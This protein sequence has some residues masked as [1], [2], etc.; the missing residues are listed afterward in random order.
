MLGALGDDGAAQPEAGGVAE[1]LD[2]G[3]LAQFFDDSGEHSVLLRWRLAGRAVAVMRR[4]GPMRTASVDVEAQRLGDGGDAGVGEGRGARA[5]QGRGEV[6]DDL[7]D[8]SGGD[9]GAGQGGAAFQQY[10]ARRRGRTG[11]PS[12]AGDADAAVVPRAAGARS[13]PGEVP[14]VGVLG[15]G[16]Q[17]GR[18]VVED[19]GGRAGRG[20]LG[21]ED[22]PQRLGRRRRSPRTARCGSSARSGAGAD[23]DGVGLG[24]QPV[25]VGAGLGAS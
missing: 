10:G 21:V 20:A 24:A 16:D 19:A 14:G 17:G 22:D 3:D 7:V 9:E 15:D 2:G 6:A 23:D 18:G 13:T 5:E 4:S 12:R 1:L 8:G 25:D 11:R